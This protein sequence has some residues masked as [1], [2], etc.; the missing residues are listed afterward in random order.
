[1]SPLWELWRWFQTNEELLGL[2]VAASFVLLIFSLALLPFVVSLIPADY[3]A[4]E[5]RGTSRLAR[6]HPTA[7]A[8]LMVVKNLFGVVFFLAGVAMLVL[9]GQGLLTM[10]V[11]ILLLDFPGKYRL[12]WRLV[13]HPRII[14]GINWLRRR[15]RAEPLTL[16]PGADDGE[17]D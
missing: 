16:P 11:A 17:G 3:F 8:L 10:V 6:L 1:M 12:E 9:P 5:Q 7:H 2:L 15:A 4:R 14:R 13:R